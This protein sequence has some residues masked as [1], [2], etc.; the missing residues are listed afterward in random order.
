MVVI[1]ISLND[2][3]FFI[4]RLIIQYEPFFG[5]HGKMPVR[6]LEVPTGLVVHII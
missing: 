6:Q 5:H 2:G 4:Q 1:R 3:A